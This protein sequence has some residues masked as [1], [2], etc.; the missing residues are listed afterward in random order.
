MKLLRNNMI[1]GKKM[2]QMFNPLYAEQQQNISQ[3]RKVGIFRRLSYALT[4][5]NQSSKQSVRFVYSM[6]YRM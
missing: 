5:S 3:F 2:A 6:I 1:K 4:V